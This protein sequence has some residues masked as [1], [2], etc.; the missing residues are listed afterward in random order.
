MSKLL[1]EVI[2][3][4]KANPDLRKHLLPVIRKHAALDPANLKADLNAALKLA[5]QA[6]LQK[7][8]EYEGGKPPKDRGSAYIRFT[9][10]SAGAFNRGMKA[11]ASTGFRGEYDVELSAGSAT[12]RLV[13][14][15]WLLSLT[16]K[17]FDKLP[18][19]ME[20]YKAGLEAALTYLTSK[21]WLPSS[22]YISTFA[23][24]R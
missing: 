20:V 14:T 17:A 10:G 18:N 22:A 23:D 1:K 24:R 3:V 11:L 8:K 15:D 13:L 5:G 21:K 7:F 19:S 9:S 2:K 4:A 12:V 16:P 6:A